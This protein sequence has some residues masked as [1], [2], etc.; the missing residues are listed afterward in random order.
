MP[1]NFS[2]FNKIKKIFSELL[3]YEQ[4]FIK[5]S[6]CCI[7][8]GATTQYVY[9]FYFIEIV[10]ILKKDFCLFILLLLLN[11]D[12]KSQNKHNLVIKQ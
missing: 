6:Y 10:F 11:V 12:W 4:S 7:V 2:D 3:I 9:P 1:H 8:S 5:K